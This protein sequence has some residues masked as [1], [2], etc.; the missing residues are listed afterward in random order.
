[1]IY[2]WCVLG[3]FLVLILALIDAFVRPDPPTDDEVKEY[4]KELWR[5]RAEKGLK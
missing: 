5:I 2:A 1:M 3:F 4:E